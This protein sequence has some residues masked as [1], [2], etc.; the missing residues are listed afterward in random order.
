MNR[1]LVVGDDWFP[2][3][4]QALREEELVRVLTEPR[5]ALCK[6]YKLQFHLNCTDFVMT[7]G[8]H[9]V[10]AA[11]ARRRGTG[12]RSLRSLLDILL[13]DALFHVRLQPPA[14]SSIRLCSP[15][16]AHRQP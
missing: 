7:E 6:Q 1:P 11:A 5:S 12:A 14:V 16:G 2:P 9:H 15:R 4:L 10:V 3:L 8:A 13:C